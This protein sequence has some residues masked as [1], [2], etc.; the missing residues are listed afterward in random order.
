VPVVYRLTDDSTGEIA[1]AAE[2]GSTRR[3][4]GLALSAEDSQELFRRSGVIRRVT[5]AVPADRLL[6]D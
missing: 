5:V 2:D 1:L 6:G 3:V 4:A